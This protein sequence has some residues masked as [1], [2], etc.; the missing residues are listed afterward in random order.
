M[1][2]HNIQ[3]SRVLEFQGSRVP[4]FQG[5][6]VSGFQGSRVPGFQGFRVPGFQGSRVQGFK[7]FELGPPRSPARAK[8]RPLTHWYLPRPLRMGPQVMLGVHRPVAVGLT[9]TC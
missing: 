3:G 6:R 8:A 9:S 5:F 7:V 1:A 4:G 2:V